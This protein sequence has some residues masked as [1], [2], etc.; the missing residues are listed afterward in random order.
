MFCSLYFQISASLT[1][2]D[3]IT[4]VTIDAIDPDFGKFICFIFVVGKNFANV[5]GINASCSDIVL[6]KNINY[7][8]TNSFN[9]V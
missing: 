4:F 5:V 9:V 1:V 6:F 2:I 3:S 7:F 8:V